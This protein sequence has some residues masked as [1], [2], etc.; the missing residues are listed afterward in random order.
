MQLY[1]ADCTD[2]AWVEGYMY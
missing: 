2:V 1:T